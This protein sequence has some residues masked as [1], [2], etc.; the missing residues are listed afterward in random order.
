MSRVCYIVGAGEYCGVYSPVE[1]DYIIA[2]DGGF[3]NLSKQGITPNLVVGDFD[4]LDT[5]PDHPNIIQYQAE[6]D[7][8]DMMLAINEG[9]KQGCD[10]FVI[11][12]GIGGRADHTMANYQALA[13]IACNKARGFLVGRDMTVT[14]IINDYMTFRSGARG[15][16]SVFSFG[17]IAEGVTLSG[18]KYNL[19]N[20]TLR[21]SIPLGVSNEFIGEPAS[22]GV[23]NGTLL[24]MWDSG[25]ENILGD[26]I[27]V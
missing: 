20:A 24:I 3:T 13:N 18:L 22:V 26:T 6:K 10:V 14:V 1:E 5:V 12:G 15:R 2:A 19:N 16:I 17:D 23:R 21:N 11:D 27:N 9:F 8:T 4:S 25:L 7:D